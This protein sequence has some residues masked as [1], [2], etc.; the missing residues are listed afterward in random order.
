MIDIQKKYDITFVNNYFNKNH[1]WI[2]NNLPDLSNQSVLDI[3]CGP[4]DLLS[5]ISQIYPNGNYNGIDIS[6][7]MIEKARSKFKN[8][9]NFIV[10][11]SHSL[12]YKNDRFDI[13]INTISFHHYEQPDKVIS[14]MY[15]V[16]KPGGRLLLLDSI[17]DPF[18][19]SIL[20]WYWDIKERKY[21]YTKHLTSKEF[22]SL[23]ENSPFQ[24]YNQKKYYRASPVIHL[25][26][27]A[28]K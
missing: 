24:K 25:L 22:R 16:L 28:E 10:G 19:I 27:V 18:F 3:G 5:N 26:T 4:A 6:D 14:E 17:R 9:E 12:P 23:F 21:L 15:R 2:L 20:P 1:K 11:D 7:S 8:E 13:I